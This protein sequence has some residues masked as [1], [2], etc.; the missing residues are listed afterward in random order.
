MKTLRKT[1]FFPRPIEDVWIA[2]T[3][4]Q[5]LAEWL[6]PNNFQP[7]VGRKFQFHVD[8][9]LGF[10]GVTDCEV[11]EVEPPHRLVYTWQ[12]VPKAPGAPRPAPMTLTWTL[13]RRSG[14]TELVLEQVGLET[15]GWWHRVSMTFGWSRMLKTLLPKVLTHVDGR[16][17][18]P[19]AIRKRDYGTKTVPDG[20]AK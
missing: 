8:P 12:V 13:E 17:F 15:L 9:M 2:L 11:L 18:I 3:D 19:G 20:F 14:G 10:S 7:V 1:V 4:P 6:M 16:R 5:A